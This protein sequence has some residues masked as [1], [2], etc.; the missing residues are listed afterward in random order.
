VRHSLWQLLVKGLGW[1]GVE[2]LQQLYVV[3]ASSL[4]QACWRQEAMTTR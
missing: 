1:E 4:L 3:H 2:Q